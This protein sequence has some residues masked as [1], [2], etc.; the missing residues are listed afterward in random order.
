MEPVEARQ[1]LQLFT[2]FVVKEDQLAIGALADR[3]E[4]ANHP[5]AGIT[6]EVVNAVLVV[7]DDIAALQESATIVSGVGWKI[8]F[9]PG[10]GLQT[11]NDGNIITEA[12]PSEVAIV[13]GAEGG[14]KEMLGQPNHLAPAGP[15]ELKWGETKVR[16]NVTATWVEAAARACLINMLGGLFVGAQV[17]G[18]TGDIRIYPSGVEHLNYRMKYLNDQA[19]PGTGH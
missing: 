3:L 8:D 2:D 9:V 14:W 6:R 19:A 1:V 12:Y 16:S 13:W 7:P 4:E 5:L 18:L 10:H 11:D 17:C 15:R